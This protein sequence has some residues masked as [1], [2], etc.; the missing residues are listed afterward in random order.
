MIGLRDACI[1]Y[2]NR[3]VFQGLSYA[4]SK[5]QSLAILGPNGS[6]KTTTLKATLGHERLSSGTR[7][8]PDMV[9]YVPQ[10]ASAMPRV[11]LLESVFLGRAARLGLFGQP[12]KADY[13]IAAA[14]LDRVGMSAMAAAD[15]S[16]LSGGERQLVVLARALATE[17]PVLIL[18]EP[19]SALDLANQQRFLD[20]LTDIRRDNDRAVIFTTHDPNHALALADHV[21][22]MMPGG[23]VIFGATDDVLTLEHLEALYGVRMR[24]VVFEDVKGKRR[25][26]V[27][28]A[29][30]GRNTS[31]ALQ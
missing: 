21:L 17:A 28:P 4:L 3:T 5:G 26:G 2:G 8:A 20:L 24:T 23:R 27:V 31:P 29:F 15:F 14:C 7:F 22:L 25:E 6:G 1:R 19:T 30:T 9:G 10:L 16:L 11:S 12:N 13:D 18:D